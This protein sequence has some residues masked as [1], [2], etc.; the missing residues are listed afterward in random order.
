MPVSSLASVCHGCKWRKGIESDPGYR[1]MRL[2][3]AAGFYLDRRFVPIG[4]QK[5]AVAG[6]HCR[7]ELAFCLPARGDIIEGSEQADTENSLAYRL[8]TTS[9]ISIIVIDIHGYLRPSF[10][11]RMLTIS[12]HSGR[13]IV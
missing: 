11:N 1:Y 4:Q 9:V 2:S 6:F 8:T 10:C 12:K 13:L 3:L 5:I 7:I